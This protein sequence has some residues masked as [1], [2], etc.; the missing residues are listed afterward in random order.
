LYHTIYIHLY[1]NPVEELDS[2]VEEL[3]NSVKSSAVEL[4]S[5]VVELDNSVN[6]SVKSS[7]V[8]LDNSVKSSVDTHYNIADD[9]QVIESIHHMAS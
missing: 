7:A 9:I 3:D 8:E 1:N 2:F 5:F 4:D 6:S